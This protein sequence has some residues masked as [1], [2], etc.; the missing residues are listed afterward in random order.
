MNYRK[1]FRYSG[2]AIALG[3]DAERAIIYRHKLEALLA[4]NKAMAAELIKLDSELRSKRSDIGRLRRD[5]QRAQRTIKELSC[6][7]TTPPDGPPT[8]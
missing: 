5:L 1:R 7:T 8:V 4:D 3:L 2:E 6:N